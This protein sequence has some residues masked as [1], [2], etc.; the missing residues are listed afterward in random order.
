MRVHLFFIFAVFFIAYFVFL[1]IYTDN[2]YKGS[3]LSTFRREFDK[4]LDD[5]LLDSAE[6]ISTVVYSTDRVGIDS[7]NRLADVYRRVFAEV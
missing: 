4:N 1:Y 2:M 6:A 7:V 5:R 3:L